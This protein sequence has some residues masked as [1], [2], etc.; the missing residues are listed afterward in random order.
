MDLRKLL[1]DVG[2]SGG[3]TVLD[4]LRGLIVVPIITKLIGTDAYGLWATLLGIVS[5]AT[6]LGTIDAGNALVRYTPEETREGEAF[7]D[8]LG[9]VLVTGTATAVLFLLADAA[10]GIVPAGTGQSLIYAAAALILVR[11]TST[12]VR[13][14]PQARD[15]VKF[16][17]LLNVTQ[18]VLEVAALGLVLF[19]L[20]DITA[21]F[22]ALVGVTLLVDVATLAYY[23]PTPGIPDPGDVRRYVAFSL[24]MVVQTVSS[25]TIRHVDKFLLLYFIS[26]TAAAVYAVAAA[27]GKFVENFMQALNP[28]L[29][30]KV[31]R[32]WREDDHDQLAQLYTFIF[33]WF[34]IIGLPAV[35]GLGVLSRPILA[36]V[37]TDVVATRGRLLLPAM[38]FAF[39]VGGFN[40]PLVF[41]INAAEHNEQLSISYA[42]AAAANVVLNLVFV[43]RFG[44]AA[45]A[46]TTLVS[47]AFI[48]AYLVRWTR[49]RVAF[50]LP[51]ATTLRSLVATGVMV[52]VLHRVVPPFRFP[53]MLA[54]YPMVGA[55][56]YFATMFV[57]GGV[58]R[59]ELRNVY[60]VLTG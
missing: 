4:V 49:S 51:L 37:A 5:I 39:L 7:V 13:N 21:G 9:I 28:G 43:P 31:V 17:E 23:R 26:P 50:S 54:V 32:A 58:R 10:I 44:T 11:S 6:A 20:R 19:F 35:A 1:T 25:R 55:T 22:W 18:T 16:F 30:P 46:A 15:E 47:Y 3:R 34:V 45:A 12:I 42:A 2:V 36:T 8:I 24:P 33:R 57:V 48:T 14:Y 29:Y 27:M 41:V 56:L 60:G 59:E 53:V 52:F 38:A 40:S